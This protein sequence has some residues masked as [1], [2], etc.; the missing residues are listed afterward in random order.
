MG[1]RRRRALGRFLRR[2][3]W[4]L[5]VIEDG[6]TIECRFAIAASRS[7]GFFIRCEHLRRRYPGTAKRCYFSNR[8][9][10]LR[11]RR[12]PSYHD[13]AAGSLREIDRS[14]SLAFVVGYRRYGFEIRKHGISQLQIRGEVCGGRCCW[15]LTS[16]RSFLQSIRLKL[17][18]FGTR[19]KWQRFQNVKVNQ[20]LYAAC[21]SPRRGEACFPYQDQ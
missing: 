17:V 7:G 15:R 13:V 4:N 6:F 18:I 16:R 14:A 3:G 2:F 8:K 19:D 9:W 20:Y 5:F 12:T 21:R 1:Q 10:S 11:C